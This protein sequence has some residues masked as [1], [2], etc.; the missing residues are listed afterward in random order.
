MSRTENT[1]KNFYFNLVTQILS[2]FLGFWGRAIFIKTLGSDILGLNS[3]YGEILSMLSLTDL[4]LG[5]AAR[6]SLYKP[7]AENDSKKI[8]ALIT[9][10]KKI[11]HGIAL[12]ILGIG[13]GIIPFLHH[14][15]NSVDPIQG[16]Y[17]YYIIFL[18]NT[19][20]SY[21]VAYKA[22]VIT[23]DQKGYIIARYGAILNTIKTICQVIS[24]VLWH[25]YYIYLLLA[26]IATLLQNIIVSRITEKRYPFIKRKGVLK[27]E[28]KKSLFNNI[29]SVFIYKMASVV[30]T[31]TDNTLISIIC[32]L[33]YVGLYANYKLI[34]YY[35]EVII[36][37]VFGACSASIGNLMVKEGAEERYIVFDALQTLCQI[38]SVIILGC[39][40]N[41]VNDFIICWISAEYL[42]DH[43][44]LICIAIN[45]YMVIVLK[46]TISFR[47]ATG[48][49]SKTKYF[50]IAA[51]AENLVLSI[52]LG[53]RWG[54]AGIF[55]ASAIARL[56]TYFWYEPK[57]LYSAFF[58]KEVFCYY[59]N[60][61][62]NLLAT[63]TAC[64][65]TH[66]AISFISISGW[67]GWII[68]AMVSIIIS[69]SV[70]YVIY[71]KTSGFRWLYIKILQILK[72]KPK[73]N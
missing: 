14:I 58:N 71:R 9:Y 25:N 40:Y 51:S 65:S 44:T 6:Y 7:L 61:F 28:E 70:A 19:V 15:I 10:Y 45:L 36:S 5:L 53:L 73:Y 63:L 38:L 31:S 49:Y 27:E 39:F 47:E 68:K 18:S 55:L 62:I 35:L 69:S 50:M 33:H 11:Y 37:L 1:V 56:T 3:L 26:V 66:V 42:V 41:L 12:T 34:S 54:M 43:S 64:C 72:M 2:L 52:I 46:P 48:L 60:L 13:L 17:L 59:F 8:A 32:G 21:L 24:L 22:L 23:A 29:T 4:G 57:L 30:F 16:M 67:F 20:C